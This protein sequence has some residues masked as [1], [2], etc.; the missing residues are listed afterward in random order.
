[1]S[2]KKSNKALEILKKIAIILIVIFMIAISVL[3][4]AFTPA[5]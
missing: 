3:T 5:A 1:M 2:K 4:M